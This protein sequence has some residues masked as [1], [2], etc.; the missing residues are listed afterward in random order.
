MVRTGLA[1]D[2]GGDDDDLGAGE[3]GAEL[4]SADVAGN[5]GSQQ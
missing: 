2:A 4:V 1:G 3:G 5:L